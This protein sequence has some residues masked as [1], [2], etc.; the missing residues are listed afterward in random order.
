MISIRSSVEKRKGKGDERRKAVE[1]RWL[2]ASCKR[3]KREEGK[4]RIGMG[5]QRGGWVLGEGG[6]AN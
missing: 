2:Q 4:M 6:S 5:S 3:E 1:F